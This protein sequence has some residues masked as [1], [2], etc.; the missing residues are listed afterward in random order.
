MGRTSGGG[1]SVEQAPESIRDFSIVRQH[2]RMLANMNFYLNHDSRILDFGCGEGRYVYEYRDAGFDAYGFDI[3]PAP[4]YR[5]PADEKFFGFALT[6][7]PV[8]IPEFEV[9]RRFYKLPFEADFFDFLFSTSTLEHVMDYDLA[10]SEMARVIRPGGVAIH[11]FP[12]R[13]LPVEPHI[14]VPFGGAIQHFPWFLFWACLGVRNQ[15][16]RHMGPIECAKNN[17]H[18]AKTGLNYL[19]LKEILSI[20]RRHY[21]EVKIV[22]HLWEL[23]DQAHI[24]L[25]VAMLMIPQLARY[26]RWLYSQFHIVVLFL[27]K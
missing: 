27:R 2:R 22:S 10:L 3:C 1:I 11:T 14:H 16:Q 15:F 19:G 9:D 25:K 24:N 26:V 7:K 6:G 20:S 8:N 21:R 4:Q 17:L 13:Y 23:D 18:Y 12:A 5:H